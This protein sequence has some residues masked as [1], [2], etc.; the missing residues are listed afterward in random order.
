M[1]AWPFCPST[2]VGD[3]FVIFGEVMTFTGRPFVFSPRR[4]VELVVVVVVVGGADALLSPSNPFSGKGDSF[5]TLCCLF[6]FRLAGKGSAIVCCIFSGAGTG[7][8]AGA[9][10]GT[11]GG[12][13]DRSAAARR[14]NKRSTQV[15]LH[16]S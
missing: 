8:G 4:R 6:R 9:G 1:E 2:F 14:R 16:P 3:N 15:S 5:E 7:A 11:G 13:A 10:A 12:G